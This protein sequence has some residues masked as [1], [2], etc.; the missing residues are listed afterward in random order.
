MKNCEKQHS[1]SPCDPSGIA[2]VSIALLT[3]HFYTSCCLELNIVFG[4]LLSSLFCTNLYKYK[5]KCSKSLRIL[6][7]GLWG[8]AIIDEERNKDSKAKKCWV[9]ILKQGPKRRAGLA[10]GRETKSL[11]A[12]LDEVA[13]EVEAEPL[14]LSPERARRRFSLVTFLSALLSAR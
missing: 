13:R 4:L 2:N 3:R 6:D 1:H 11:D 9:L 5:H 8:N 14:P 12:Y 10:S 7:Y